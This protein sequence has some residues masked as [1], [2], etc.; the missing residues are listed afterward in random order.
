M[1]R[2]SFTKR[3][4]SAVHEVL[5]YL[6]GWTPRDFADHLDFDPEDVDAWASALDK[7]SA[8]APSEDKV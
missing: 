3:E 6:G 7:V 2:I 1:P 4:L 5:A 8:A